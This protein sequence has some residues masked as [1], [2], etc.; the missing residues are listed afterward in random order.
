[1]GSS[2]IS[3]CHREI[4]DR[5][6]FFEPFSPNEAMDAICAAAEGTPQEKP[7][8]CT[9]EAG[10]MRMIDQSWRSIRCEP[11]DGTGNSIVG[12]RRG[13]CWIVVGLVRRLL[14]LERRGPS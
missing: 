9:F 14:G 3:T 12:S 7:A 2:V 4:P 11:I 10:N 5:D 1:M 13:R 8:R 6:P